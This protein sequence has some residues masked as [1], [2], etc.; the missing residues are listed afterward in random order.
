[1]RSSLMTVAG[2]VLVVMLAAGISAAQTL[3][4][5]FAT[6]EE[7][8]E[9]APDNLSFR[10][11]VSKKTVRPGGTAH[12]AVE[13]GIADGFWVYGPYAAGV[14][15]PAQSLTVKPGP[16]KLQV[17]EAVFSGTHEHV[18]DFPDGSKDVHNVYEGKGY[19][20]VPVTVPADLPAGEHELSLRVEGQLC[21]PQVCIQVDTVV[22]AV[23]RVGD[24]DEATPDWAGP[25]SDGLT[26]AKTA[27]QWKTVLTSKTI[28]IE[29]FRGGDM[30]N[31]GALT[32]LAVAWLAGLLLNIMPCVLPVLPLRLLTLLNQAGQSR[33][34]FIALGLAFAFGVF[35]FFVA[36]AG[37]NAGLK[38]AIG[39]TLK[40]GDLFRHPEI[41]T[42][43]ALLLT[44]LAANM[45]GVFELHLPGRVA[46]ARTGSGVAGAVG[47]GFLVAVL[48]T[49][50]SGAVL[51]GAFTW[52]QL[53]PL[54]IG[55]LALMM[56]GA[57]MA[58]PHAVIAFFP[59]IVSRL[60]RAGAW[61]GLF[62]QFVGFV[63]LMIVAW[64]I[65]TLAP[66]ST[67][68]WVLAFAVVLGMCLWMWGQ[69]V[70]YTTPPVRKWLA[71]SAAVVLAVT[72]GVVMLSPSGTLT[73]W[74]YDADSGDVQSAPL[75][76]KAFDQLA[77]DQARSE[78][79]TV[80]VKFTANWCVECKWV[81]MNVYDRPAVSQGLRKRGV[82]VF[83]GDV[84]NRDMPADKMLY[85]QLGQSGPPLTVIFP[86]GNKPAIV[87]RGGFNKDDLFQALDQAQQAPSDTVTSD[88]NPPD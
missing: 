48:A 16:T 80:L 3:E 86:P 88:D 64:M 39:Y 20:W 21:S 15:V 57:G 42:G 7:G 27:D 69:W 2:T 59:Q 33:R 26:K 78:D 49:P 38:M 63:L 47:M 40:W 24:A 44:A 75:K 41:V 53:K 8:S 31:M 22:K 18:T 71:R 17:G 54:W 34:R 83:E 51:A 73:R 76:M 70:G 84:T 66:G 37:A 25:L 6:L 12:V 61:T 10:P 45:F 19:V 23:I 4:E 72:A 74:L 11:V 68:G 30:A 9:T 52:A 85:D 55:T 79:K 5:P 56:M 14:Q 60:P 65:G 82:V 77:F 1:M 50:C 81:Q 36:I 46:E 29:L 32:G 62:K 58:T 87:L 43:L 28:D 67:I 35:L 13:I